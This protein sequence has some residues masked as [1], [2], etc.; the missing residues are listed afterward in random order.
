MRYT[1]GLLRSDT[2]LNMTEIVKQNREIIAKR[3]NLE[4]EAQQLNASHLTAQL[5]DTNPDAY[6][7]YVALTVLFGMNATDTFAASIDGTMYYKPDEGTINISDRE[8]FQ[9]A[10]QGIPNISEKIKSPISN[11]E[12]YVL[13]VPITYHGVTVGTLHK[14]Y[15][16][17]KLY[18]LCTPPLFS[19]LGDSYLIN[20]EG[21]ILLSS[22]NTGKAY[23]NFFTMLLDQ[24][25]QQ[26]EK[27]VRYDMQNGISNVFMANDNNTDESFFYSYAKVN[28]VHR[29]YVVT[30]V[31]A[32]AILPNTKNVIILFYII[33]LT[34]C[35][36]F[37]IDRKSV[38]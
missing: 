26:Q 18:Q 27:Q 7:I 6:E 33:L 15:P 30:S 1:Q 5:T 9:L 11:E 20:E 37:G 32:D 29:W 4:F 23:T 3:I 34:I 8:Y 16:P 36:F 2:I 13:S 17:K 14:K 12:I 31:E 35:I 22:K 38:V 28:D 10:L 19:E 21:E 25:N 24:G